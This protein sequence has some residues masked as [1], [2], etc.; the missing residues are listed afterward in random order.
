M[1]RAFGVIDMRAYHVCYFIVTTLAAAAS[2][3]FCQY[4]GQCWGNFIKGICNSFG[5]DIFTNTDDHGI[6]PDVIIV[7]MIMIVD[8]F[9]NC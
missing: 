6:I 2:T 8:I 9:V 3:C 1:V 4:R 7:Q 5:I